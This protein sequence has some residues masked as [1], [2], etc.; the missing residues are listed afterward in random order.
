MPFIPQRKLLV[1]VCAWAVQK[2]IDLLCHIIKLIPVAVF[3]NVVGSYKVMSEIVLAN[4]FIELVHQAQY[5]S[6]EI[7]PVPGARVLLTCPEQQCLE[8]I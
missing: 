3:Q 1:N 8:V 6:P 4:T 2:T 7:P 5:T